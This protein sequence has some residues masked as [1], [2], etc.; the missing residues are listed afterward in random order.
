MTQRSKI[1]EG[2]LMKCNAPVFSLVKLFLANLKC[3]FGSINAHMTIASQLDRYT[4][5]QI[6]LIWRMKAL[7]APSEVQK[8]Q[9]SKDCRILLSKRTKSSFSNRAFKNCCKNIDCYAL[10]LGGEIK[11]HCRHVTLSPF[12]AK[13][14][15][16]NTPSFIIL[17]LLLAVIALPCQ[18][19]IDFHR[20]R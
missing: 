5:I 15:F 12:C 11:Q 18:N 1:L 17:L 2:A 14:L 19:L 7:I 9:L 13:R 10:D 16:E 20:S 6:S 3:W 4:N 8:V